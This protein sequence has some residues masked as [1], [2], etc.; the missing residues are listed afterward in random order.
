MMRFLVVGGAVVALVAAAAGLAG[1]GDAERVAAPVG[2]TAEALGADVEAEDPE[3]E[4]EGAPCGPGASRADERADDEP[5]ENESAENERSE[6]EP[7]DNE[8]DE[9]DGGG[10][11]EP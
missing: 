10:T 11:R 4:N 6:N 2:R 1:V 5:S 8:P 7:A 9:N 3:N